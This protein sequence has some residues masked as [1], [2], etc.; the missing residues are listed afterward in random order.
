MCVCVCV[1]YYVAPT[2]LGISMLRN[3]S[4]ES[5]C[6]LCVTPQCSSIPRLIFEA[7]QWSSEHTNTQDVFGQKTHWWDLGCCEVRQRVTH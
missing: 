5:F 2:C 3:P 4:V 6:T 7:T 1:Y